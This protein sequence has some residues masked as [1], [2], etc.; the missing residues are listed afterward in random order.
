MIG[1]TGHGKSS[2]CNSIC[3]G[4]RFKAASTSQSVTEK[5]SG[6]LV[7]WEGKPDGEPLIVIDCPGFG[8]SQ[9]RD[10]EHIADIVYKL[11]VIHYVH[12]FLIVI[13][14]DERYNQQLQSTITLLSQMFG[15]EFFQNAMLV[16]TKF[17]QNDDSVWARE[18][19]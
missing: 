4:N 14:S 3:G 13:N 18:N 9:G 7:R 8:D 12:S 10:T 15:S 6:V 5:V 1:V 16:F 17:T 2:T 19:G 11:R